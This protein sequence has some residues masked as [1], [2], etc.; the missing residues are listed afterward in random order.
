MG[1]VLISRPSHKPAENN[2]P[3][4][5]PRILKIA[6]GRERHRVSFHREMTILMGRFLL[7]MTRYLSGVSIKA[8]DFPFALTVR[9][10]SN[11]CFK[12]TPAAF[13][14]Y[15]ILQACRSPTGV[16]WD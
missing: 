5:W 11:G 8:P 9:W 14:L 1:I 7:T 2:L 12:R 3:K 16:S 13:A 6:T 10:G 4:S 15:S